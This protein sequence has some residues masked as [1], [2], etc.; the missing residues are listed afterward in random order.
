MATVITAPVQNTILND[1]NLTEIIIEDNA[2]TVSGYGANLN[3]NGFLYDGVRMP[4]IMIGSILPR[5]QFFL[6][7]NNLLLKSITHPTVTNQTVQNFNVIN[8]LEIAIHHLDLQGYPHSAFTFNYKLKYSQFSTAERYELWPL[9]FI[10]VDPEVLLHQ[11]QTTIQLPVYVRTKDL[12][13]TIE[14]VAEDNTVISAITYAMPLET[15]TVL[16]SLNVNTPAHVNAYYFRV[17]QNG[18]SISKKIKVVRH[19]YF[20]PKKVR[21]FNRFGM[22]VLTELFGKITTKDEQTFHKYQNAQNI[23]NTAEVQQDR[24]ITVDTGYLLEAEKAI[25]NQIASSL[26]VQVEVNGVFTPC[27]VTTKNVPVFTENEFISSTQ[28]TF[29]FN[30]NPKLKN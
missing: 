24:L 9:S 29:E 11:P 6:N 5:R 4:K 15:N 14:A 3:I 2:T 13:I 23:Y 10:A 8:D 12:P 18:Y 27:V 19:N 22:P 26:N 20:Q 1:A 30:P 17:T 16:L 25:V 28:L 21:F 7:F